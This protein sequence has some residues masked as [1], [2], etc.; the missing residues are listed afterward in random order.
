MNTVK[1]FQNLRAGRNQTVIVYGTSLTA[2]GARA[3]ALLEQARGA[4]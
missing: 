1:F 3:I 2:G 4:K